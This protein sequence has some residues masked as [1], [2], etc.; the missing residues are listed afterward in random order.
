MEIVGIM[1]QN[2]EMA[3]GAQKAIEAANKQD[4]IK[5]IGIDAIPDA[6]SA[7]E[8]GKLIATVFQDA[9]SQARKALEVAVMAVKGEAVDSEYLIDFK[10][11]TA[12]NVAEY[13]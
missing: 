9:R 12:E 2:D 10:L 11:I 7:V 8:A 1:A 13:K 4:A 3:I 6:L 5:V